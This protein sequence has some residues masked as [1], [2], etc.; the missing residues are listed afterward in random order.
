MVPD[1]IGP[2][3][4]VAASLALAAVAGALDPGWPL[5]S[6]ALWLTPPALMAYIVRYSAWASD[7]TRLA[8]ALAAFGVW[9]TAA[10]LLT[11]LHPY[12]GIALWIG[13]G[14]LVWALAGLRPARA[15]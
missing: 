8:I 6:V 13:V 4:V 3:H 11:V 12:G 1:R 7:E 9:F 5:G 2:W 14:G 15:T 10:L